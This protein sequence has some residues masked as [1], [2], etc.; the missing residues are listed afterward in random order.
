MNLPKSNFAPFVSVLSENQILPDLFKWVAALC[1]MAVFHAL[2]VQ[3][4][5]I[6]AGPLQAR[7]CRKLVSR[8]L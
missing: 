8:R 1:K 5:D 6:A 3:F 2:T 7:G 4:S